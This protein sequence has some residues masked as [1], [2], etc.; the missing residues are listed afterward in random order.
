MPLLTIFFQLTT[1]THSA[2]LVDLLA[3][4]E[5]CGFTQPVSSIRF[6]LIFSL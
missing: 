2:V 5:R 1:V 3:L 4:T 6:R